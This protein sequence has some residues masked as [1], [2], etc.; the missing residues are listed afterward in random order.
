MGVLKGISSLGLVALALAVVPGLAGPASAQEP[1][2]P[3][4]AGEPAPPPPAQPTT[5]AP[6]TETSPAPAPAA[7]VC[8]QPAATVR[9]L[10]FE[11]RPRVGPN[12][13]HRKDVIAPDSTVTVPN[14]GWLSFRIGD[15]GELRLGQ[16]RLR[17]ACD[18]P[19]VLR[20]G[21]LRLTDAVGTI[22]TSQG[23]FA[24]QAPE[25]RATL[26]VTTGLTRVWFYAGRGW[27]ARSAAPDGAGRIDLLPGDKAL[28][29]QDRRPQLDTWPFAPSP[30][31]RPATAAD[32]LPSFW[33]DGASCSTGCRPAGARMGWPIKPFDQ[34]HGL[35]AGLNERRRANMHIGVDIQARDG[36]PVYAIQSGTA[37]VSAAGS[38][39]ERVQVG[40]FSYWH[41]N[42]KV[43]SGQRVVAYKT[44]I[45][46]VLKHAGHVHL[47]ELSGGRYLNPL[48]PGG[49]SSDHGPTRSLRSSTNHRSPA[50]QPATTSSSRR[51]THSPTANWSSTERQ[52]W[53]SPRWH[54]AHLT[55]PAEM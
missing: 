44:V 22:D 6:P 10:S 16:G 4:P 23:A 18:G 32:Q 34:P 27:V 51:S 13:L 11:H 21:T 46:T 33:A 14:G 5:P 48:R 28:L 52:Y 45:G 9:S 17:L 7:P 8:T 38:V 30:A 49:A 29:R 20:S 35:R 3:R 54:T 41:I 42:H 1:E 50:T 53:H 39:D 15:R 47:S 24:V 19:P 36:Q 43:S 55:G 40:N 31:Q 26:V 2:A 12:V 25:A 37:S